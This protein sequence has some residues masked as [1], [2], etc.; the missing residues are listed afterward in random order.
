MTRTIADKICPVL[1][2][3]HVCILNPLFLFA[4]NAVFGNRGIYGADPEKKT[5]NKQ[6]M[7][8]AT[9]VPKHTLCNGGLIMLL[10]KDFLANVGP[11]QVC[12]MQHNLT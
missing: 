12:V 7:P 11:L 4:V 6:L 8:P 3:I 1:A 9:S 10:T 5:R 2:I